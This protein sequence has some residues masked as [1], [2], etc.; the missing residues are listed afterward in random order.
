LRDLHGSF[1]SKV[2]R[3]E[4]LGLGVG[5]FKAKKVLDLLPEIE[6]KRAPGQRVLISTACRCHGVI[7]A[8]SI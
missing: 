6:K 7:S 5:G 1:K 8:L 2:I 3:S 4:Q